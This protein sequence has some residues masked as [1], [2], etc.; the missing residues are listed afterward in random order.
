MGGFSRNTT[1]K[2]GYATFA[3]WLMITDSLD[4]QFNVR[5]FSQG[6]RLERWEHLE[7]IW[8]W[9]HAKPTQRTNHER[10]SAEGVIYTAVV[11]SDQRRGGAA[12][13]VYSNSAQFLYL[14]KHCEQQRT[15]I[16]VV[17]FRHFLGEFYFQRHRNS[18]PMGSEFGGG[19]WMRGEK[20]RGIFLTFTARI[21]CLRALI[22]PK[23]EVN[24]ATTVGL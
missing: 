7:E 20:N 18:G 14:Y 22:P 11:R 16:S 17:R 9:P 15:R 3:G 5:F 19:G 13:P 23:R 12:V 24:T 1:G 2:D 10:W 21:R 8:T 6:H 4:F